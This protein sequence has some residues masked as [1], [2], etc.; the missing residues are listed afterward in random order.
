MCRKKIST[1][2]QLELFAEQGIKPFEPLETRGPIYNIT[3]GYSNDWIIY[4]DKDGGY[5]LELAHW[6]LIPFWTKSK[7]DAKKNS[8][9]MVNARSETIYEKPAYKSLVAANRCLIPAGGFYEWNHVM[10]GKKDTAIP[11]YISSKDCK[12]FGIAGL[13]TAWMDKETGE[14]IP[15]FTM[16]TTAANELMAR[17]H[18]HGDN[19][20]RMPLI[21]EPGMFRDW[22]DPST[23]KQ[24]VDEMLAYRV[25]SEKLDAWPV[26]KISPRTIDGPEMIERVK[27]AEID[28]A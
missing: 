16:I 13:R 5:H 4:Q 23:P 9:N 12:G 8:N 14:V 17:I 22:L 2:E 25:A 6:G 7:A 24:H 26:N 15:S 10:I 19:K 18:N 1:S 11:F 3:A 28:W 20:H 27:Y 21:L